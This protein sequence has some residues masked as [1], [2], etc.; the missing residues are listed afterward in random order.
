[1]SADYIIDRVRAL[2]NEASARLPGE[3]AAT[4][5]EAVTALDRPLH[6]AFVG[7]VSSGKS[8]LVN[9][10]LRR[11]LAPT[12]EGE[13]TKVVTYVSFGPT[14]RARAVLNDGSVVPVALEPDGGLPSTIGIDPARVR[15]VEVEMSLATLKGLT[16]IDTPGLNSV[17]DENSQRTHQALGID[18]ASQSAAA[19]AD[20]IIFILNA[21]A[22]DDEQDILRQF[23]AFSLGLGSAPANAVAVLAKAD[24]VSMEEDP[25]PTAIELARRHGRRLGR[26]LAAVL[27]VVGLLAESAEARFDEDD[28][29]AIR[30]LSALGPDAR[31]EMLLG[32]SYL[33]A[34]PCAVDADERARLYDMLRSYGLRALLHA[35]DGGASGPAMIEDLRKRSGMKALRDEIDQRF[36]RRAPALKAA[37][38]LAALQQAAADPSVDYPDRRWVAGAV[39]DLSL[40]PAMHSLEELRALT[41]IASDD[42]GFTDEEVREADGILGHTD[43]VRT[44]D[45]L[46]RWTALAST[47]L[48][49]RARDAARVVVRTLDLEMDLTP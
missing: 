48:D 16:I 4:V 24:E 38:A 27:P 14:E 21:K 7:R 13:C 23:R 33:C 29:A 32:V 26:E 40:D 12:D 10:Y 46:G 31:E 25:M 45:A 39:D 30:A 11:R 2:C 15:A 22:H 41:L 47:S 42:L 43:G 49:P 28:A 8:T 18:S 1:M 44:G 3:P 19:T 36:R 35:A 5:R 17:R 20:A 6:L 34:L 9:S 37:R